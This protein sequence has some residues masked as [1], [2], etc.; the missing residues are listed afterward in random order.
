MT[1]SA[2]ASQAIAETGA[3]HSC[4][5]VRDESE[6]R[7]R[8][9]QMRTSPSALAVARLRPSG[10]QLTAVTAASCPLSHSCHHMSH[11]TAVTCHRRHMSPPSHS[12]PSPPPR[13]PS[14]I[15]GSPT[16]QLLTA[17]CPLSHSWVPHHTNCFWLMGPQPFLS[18]PQRNLYL[19]HAPSGVPRTPTTQLISASCPLSHSWVRHHTTARPSAT[20]SLFACTTWI[21]GKKAGI[22]YGSVP[23]S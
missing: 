17:S 2:R 1:L 13:A 14:A 23:E 4:T 10:D 8:G 9:A 6:G 18:P 19:A 11:V 12:L 22:L 3:P 20:S 5:A 16:T 21:N 15:P 7:D